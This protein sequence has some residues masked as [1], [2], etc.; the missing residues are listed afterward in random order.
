MRYFFAEKP[1]Q[2]SSIPLTPNHPIETQRHVKN[3]HEFEGLYDLTSSDSDESESE[4]ESDDNA[5]GLD[6]EGQN[7][8]LTV[9]GSV[10][11]CRL[12][13]VP[14][15]EQRKLDVSY[16]KARKEKRDRSTQSLQKAFNDIEKLMASKKTKFIS[17]PRGLQ[18]CRTHAIHAHLR[19]IVCNG[20]K[21]VGA[22]HIA[23][24]A[25]G[26]SPNWGACQLRS[27]TRK[28][29]QKQDLLKS[30]VGQ[31]MKSYSLLEDPAIVAKLCSY[32][33]S[34]KW[35]VNPEKLAEFAQDKLIPEVAEKYLQEIVNEEM[36]RGLKRYM[37]LELFPRIHLKVG[38][39]ISLRTAHR[40]LQ[41]E[42]F[43]YISHKKGLYFDGHDWP[44]VVD[45]RQ[46][47]FLPE[48]KEYGRRL[49]RFTVNDVE[50]EADNQQG[51]FVEKR[52]VLCA[53]DK[54]TAQSNDSRAR[55]WVLE[56]HH[57]LR[58]KGAGRGI[59]QSDVICSTV[60]WLEKGSQTLEYGKNYEGYWTG[61]LFVKQ[62]LW[63]SELLQQI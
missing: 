5:N 50:N 19:L 1:K 62:V 45:Y 47:H 63:P 38:R 41:R 30:K 2:S 34:N 24:E 22:S 16:R 31:H 20:R 33:C 29:E 12:P 49:V 15:L 36:P 52:L 60:G 46:H 17:G 42:S 55:S 3:L 14:V 21:F 37:E 48:M 23:A 32:V 35:A 10:V 25:N 6:S 44:D 13:H 40:W 8:L 54:M 53:H 18:A 26:F 59:H 61:E 43:H 39:G 11:H 27:W 28:W 58:K 56:D 4:R 57:Q 9:E 7:E 51:N